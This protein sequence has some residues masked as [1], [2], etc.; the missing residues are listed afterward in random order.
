MTEGLVI[1]GG[2]LGVAQVGT[3]RPTRRYCAALDHLALVDEPLD[4]LH[5]ECGIPPRGD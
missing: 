5:E 2:L 4:R 3:A 1:A